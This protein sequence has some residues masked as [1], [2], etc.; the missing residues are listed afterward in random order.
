MYIYAQWEFND[1][2]GTTWLAFMYNN[3]LEGDAT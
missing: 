1:Y 3:V 2:K